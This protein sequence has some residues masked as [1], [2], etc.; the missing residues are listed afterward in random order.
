MTD[1]K[2][3]DLPETPGLVIPAVESRSRTQRSIWGIDPRTGFNYIG[4]VWQIATG[5]WP[6]SAIV[7]CI[8]NDFIWWLPFAV[9]L[10]DAWPFFR[11]D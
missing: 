10:R 4:M 3:A 7:L 1:D 11:E 5:V 8:T 6:R 2:F 9:Y